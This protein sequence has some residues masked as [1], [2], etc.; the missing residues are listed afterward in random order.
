MSRP[1]NH[2]C[3]EN[4]YVAYQAGQF[5]S[6]FKNFLSTKRGRFMTY[7]AKW[8]INGQGIPQGDSPR[9]STAV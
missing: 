4:K 7:Y 5:D 6:A 2:E 9:G 3:D 1:A 8:L